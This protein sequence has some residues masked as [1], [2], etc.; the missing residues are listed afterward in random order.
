M[1]KVIDKLIK[2]V[3]ERCR[4][5]VIEARQKPKIAIN[6]IEHYRE[7]YCFTSKKLRGGLS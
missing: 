5:R 2:D 7:K 6:S 4:E 3:T 1:S